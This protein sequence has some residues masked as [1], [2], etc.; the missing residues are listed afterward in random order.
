MAY[1]KMPGQPTYS[2]VFI[3]E[4]WSTKMIEKYYDATV[5]TQISNTDYEGE[6]KSQGDKVIIRTNATMEIMDYQIGQTLIN[7]RPVGGKLELLI[8]KGMYWSAIIDDVVEKQQD[9]N[10]MN[11]WAE[12]AARTADVGACWNP[13]RSWSVRSFTRR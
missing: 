9:I 8:D 5:L 12:D 7:Q 11:K 3:P 4:I 1:P 6:I 10:Q 13:A 2:G